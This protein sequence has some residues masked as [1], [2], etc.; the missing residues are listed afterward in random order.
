MEHQSALKIQRAWWSYISRRRY[1]YDDECRIC[2][3][4]DTLYGQCLD[5]LKEDARDARR[6]GYD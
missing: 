3:S 6:C 1:T 4:T 2:R 5:C